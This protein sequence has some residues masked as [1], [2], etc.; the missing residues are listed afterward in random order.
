MLYVFAGGEKTKL[1]YDKTHMKQMWTQ[2]FVIRGV[3]LT[4]IC[5]GVS[6]YCSRNTD[7]K[8]E[9]L[10]TNSCVLLPYILSLYYGFGLSLFFTI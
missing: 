1:N 6:L 10:N 4:G 3:V 5:A 2:C 7:L 8:Q 9:R